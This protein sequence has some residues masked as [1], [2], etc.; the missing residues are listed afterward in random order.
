MSHLKLE[1]ARFLLPAAQLE[2]PGAVITF[3]PLGLEGSTPSPQGRY[4]NRVRISKRRS[5]GRGRGRGTGVP[6]GW[7]LRRKDKSL[8]VT[9]T[10]SEKRGAGHTGARS[11]PLFSPQVGGPGPAVTSLLSAASPG[12]SGT[13]CP[14][15]ARIGLQALPIPPPTN[16]IPSPLGSKDP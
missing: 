15:L 1:C 9:Y 16:P 7:P 6:R 8:S 4:A 5:G 11:S 10:L 14:A 3:P 13:L 2:V 12:V